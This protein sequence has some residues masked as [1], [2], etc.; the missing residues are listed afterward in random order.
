MIQTNKVNDKV[1]INKSEPKYFQCFKLNDS[2]YALFDIK[3]DMPLIIASLPIIT[4][5]LLPEIQ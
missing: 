3:M 5:T 4:S 1:V 2:S